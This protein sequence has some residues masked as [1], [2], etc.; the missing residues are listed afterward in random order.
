MSHTATVFLG[1]KTACQS[2]AGT[3]I[4]NANFQK[5]AHKLEDFSMEEFSGHRRVSVKIAGTPIDASMRDRIEAENFHSSIIELGSAFREK[6]KRTQKSSV[7]D[8]QSVWKGLG[9]D[10]QSASNIQPCGLIFNVKASSIGDARNWIWNYTVRQQAE[11]ASLLNLFSK[12]TGKAS[13][14]NPK[15]DS[16]VKEVIERE[17]N[18][19]LEPTLYHQMLYTSWT[20]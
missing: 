9:Y 18:V 7:V 6:S 3:D 14:S 19:S 5:I 11:S 2:E 10:L 4:R 15:M 8:V 16:N 12:F 13:S 1:F 20:D 17:F